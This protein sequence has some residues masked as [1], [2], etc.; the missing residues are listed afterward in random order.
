MLAAIALG[1]LI[2]AYLGNRL[3]ITYRTPLSGCARDPGTGGALGVVRWAE[4]IGFSVK[5]LEVPIWEAT[6]SMKRPGGQL[7]L[8]YGRSLLVTHDR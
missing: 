6:E 1:F 3:R 5:L 4:Q 7:H 2:L 8:D